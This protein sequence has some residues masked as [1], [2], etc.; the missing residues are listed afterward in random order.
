MELRSNKR[1]NQTP[2]KLSDQNP[3]RTKLSMSSPAKELTILMLGETGVGKS[4]FIN[5]LVN[6]LMFENIDDAAKDLQ[7]LIPTSFSVYDEATNDMKECVFGEADGNEDVDKTQSCT[8]A[9]RC[10]NFKLGDVTLK[11]IDT[12][13]IADCRGVDTDLLNLKNLLKFL[14]NYKELNAICVLL[15]PNNAK[16]GIVFKYSILELLTHLNKS[17]SDNILFL[18][19]NSRGTFYKP[20]DTAKALRKVL[21]DIHSKPPHVEIKFE[22]DNYFCFDSEAFRYLVATSEPNNVAFDDSAHGDFEKSWQRSVTECQRLFTRI[23]NLKPHLVQDTISINDIRTKILNLRKPI[24]LIAENIS[25]EIRM[26]EK[27]EKKIEE[28]TGDIEELEKELYTP[29]LDIKSRLLEHPITVCSHPD[30]CEKKSC[31]STTKVHYKSVCHKPCYLKKSDGN[32]IGDSGLLDCQAFNKYKNVGEGNWHDPKTFVPDSPLPMNSEGLVYGYDCIRVKSENCFT[33]NHPYQIHLTINYETEIVTRKIRDENKFERIETSL[34][35]IDKRKNQI[36]RIKAKV[37]VIKE[38]LRFITECSAYFAR[39][40]MNNT[41]TPFNDALEDYIKCCIANEE[42]ENKDSAVVKGYQ[43]MLD[44]YNREKETI[45]KLSKESCDLSS[46]KIDDKIGQLFKLKT[47]G[48]VIK[49]HMDL[50]AKGEK[51]KSIALEVDVP[52]GD[53]VK[54]SGL[55]RLFQQVTENLKFW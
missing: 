46:G 32:I 7:C 34:C 10:Y 15:K 51:N 20:G 26:C 52:I 13:G 4:T 11:I 50:E 47:Y 14:S 44:A 38:E 2:I 55:I 45:E 27:H 30:C 35:G 29:A 1:R 3:K 16:I 37:D 9:C 24:A 21:Q 36:A 48:Q 6:Y 42:K 22:K 28:F 40:L 17:A 31:G 43:D 8:Q 25:N 19:T 54:T 53:G 39:F 23:S 18:F 41:I 5:A 33:C 49:H 12:P